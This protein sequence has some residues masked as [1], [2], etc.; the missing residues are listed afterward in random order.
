MPLAISMICSGKQTLLELSD[1]VGSLQRSEGCLWIS[2]SFCCYQTHA[3]MHEFGDWKQ[4]KEFEVKWPRKWHFDF[5]FPLGLDFPFSFFFIRVHVEAVGFS[6]Q[7]KWIFFP[8]ELWFVCSVVAASP[9]PGMTFL[10]FP[11]HGAPKNKNIDE[12]KPKMLLSS[13]QK[14]LSVHSFQF[15][16]TSHVL[17]LLC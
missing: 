17:L 11:W 3:L 5:L 12:Q 13:K 6:C 9:C 8:H 14:V 16:G 1:A 10:C 7:V 15:H 4:C 2:F